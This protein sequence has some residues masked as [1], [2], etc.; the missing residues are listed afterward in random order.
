[1]Y[2]GALGE[3]GKIKSLKKKKKENT[4]VLETLGWK[5]AAQES[6]EP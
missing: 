1:M 6:E 3:K 5:M 4:R 2:Q